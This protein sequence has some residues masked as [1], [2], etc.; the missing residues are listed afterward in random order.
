MA[1]IVPKDQSINFEDF[2]NE[3]G[4]IYWWASEFMVMLGYDDI[5]SFKKAIDKAMK[6]CISLGIDCLDNFIKEQNN[7]H[8]DYK[9]TRFACYLTAMNA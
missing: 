3:N 8:E 6:A 5:H 2:K 4:L 1:D 7:G 9:M